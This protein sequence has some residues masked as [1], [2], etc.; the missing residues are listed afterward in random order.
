MKLRYNFRLY[1]DEEQEA[2]MKQ[3]AGNTRFI[4]NYF[5]TQNRLHYDL[6]KRFVFEFDMNNEL[7]YVK[8][9]YEWLNTSYSQVLQAK[10]KDLSKALKFKKNNRGFPH[11]QKKWNAS[12][13]FRYVQHTKIIDG[14]LRLPKIGDIR[15]KLHRDLPKYSSVTIYQDAGKWYASFVIEVDEQPKVK[16][17]TSIGIDVNAN[18]I[19]DSNKILHLTPRPNRKYKQKLKFLQQEVSRK[20]KKSKNRMKAMARLKRFSAHLRNIRLNFLHQISARITKAADLVLVETLN[21]EEMKK[22]HK[23]AIAVQDNGWAALFGLL[24]YKCELIGHHFHKINKWLAS[25]KTCHCC[26]NKKDKLDLSIRT[27]VCDEC[28]HIEDRDINAALNIDT[29]GWQEVMRRVKKS[30]PERAKVLLDVVLDTLSSDGIS[31]TQ[32]KEEAATSLESR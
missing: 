25:S 15:I 18:N 13:S 6:Y 4:W 2:S 9:K 26:G 12:D 17:D 22:N 21:I 31:S 19:A 20:K 11:Y 14:K 24:Q 8:S 23:V 7:P 30:G 5:L 3:T 16:I 29:W 28:G 1:P 27:Y 32:L 10:L